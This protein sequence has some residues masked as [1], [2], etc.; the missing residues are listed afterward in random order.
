MEVPSSAH[1][2]YSRNRKLFRD[3]SEGVDAESTDRTQ[4]GRR[5]TMFQMASTPRGP[6]PEDKF[7]TTVPH[8]VGVDQVHIVAHTPRSSK[9]AKLHSVAANHIEA[10]NKVAQ[11]PYEKRAFQM[12]DFS[13]YCGG[14]DT[15]QSAYAHL[16]SSA[17]RFLE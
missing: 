3:A 7:R 10:T 12:Q 15:S 9:L 17:E 4:H 11:R 2:L 14:P 5:G 8:L 6:Q 1:S 16:R 13:G